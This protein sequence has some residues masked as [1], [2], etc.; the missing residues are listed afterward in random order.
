MLLIK[1]NQIWQ[2]PFLVEINL[3]ETNKKLQNPKQ[4]LTCVSQGSES[5]LCCKGDMPGKYLEVTVLLT[6]SLNF[7]IKYSFVPGISFHLTSW[8]LSYLAATFIRF[9]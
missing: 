8:E 5:K 9:I 7:T 1:F 3:I 6:L 4:T 2:Y